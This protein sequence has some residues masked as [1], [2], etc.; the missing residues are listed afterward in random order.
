MGKLL[1]NLILG[2]PLALVKK[3]S[4][5]DNLIDLYVLMVGS[6]RLGVP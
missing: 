4:Y 3:L 2:E 5:F 1:L 6:L